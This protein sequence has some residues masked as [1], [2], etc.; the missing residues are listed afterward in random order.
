VPQWKSVR[1]VKDGE[2]V[3]DRYAFLTTE[4]N[5]EVAPIHPKAMP[6]I[7]TKSDDW[8]TWL[9]VEWAEAKALQRPLAD[10]A[11]KIIKRVAPKEQPA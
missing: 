1:K 8:E 11:L 2:T 9:S 3:D 6:T 7:L 5:A 4:P 10:G